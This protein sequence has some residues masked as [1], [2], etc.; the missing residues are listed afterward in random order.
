[1]KFSRFAALFVVI[2]VFN[3]VFAGFAFADTEASSA[4]TSNYDYLIIGLGLAFVCMI[5]IGIKQ[6][7]QRRN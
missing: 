5:S 2:L 1:L 6:H 3:A 7:H 4:P